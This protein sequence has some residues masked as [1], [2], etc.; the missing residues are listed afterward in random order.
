MAFASGKK[1]WGISDRSGKRYRLSE[2]KKEWTGLLVGPDEWEEKHPQLFPPRVGPDPQAL[3]NPRPDRTEPAVEVLLRNNPLMSGGV[4]TNVITILE[5][6][7][8]RSTSDVIRLRNAAPFDGF[9]LLVLNDA[10]GYSITVVDTD[11]YTISVSDT[12]QVGG[13]RG[14]GDF[15]SAGPITVEA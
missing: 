4:G 13:L 10:N 15:V 12:A 5:P 3:R 8:G 6:G 7:H 2:M 1:A 9:T 14:G 11:T